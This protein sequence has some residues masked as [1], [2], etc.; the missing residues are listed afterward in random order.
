MF[1][2]CRRARS[3]LLMAFV[4]LTLILGQGAASAHEQRGV[5]GQNIVVGW[6]VEPAFTGS[7][8]AVSVRVTDA[9]SGQPVQGLQLKVEV[10]FG[11]RDSTQKT[12]PL[13]LQPAFNEPG[14]YSAPILPSRPGT[15]TFHITGQLD[16]EPFDQYFTSG[17]DTFD[18]IHNAREFPVEDPSPG[19]LA[20]RLSR[21]D[22]RIET[23][24]QEA[25]MA[26]SLA[27]GGIALG[28]IG[29]LVAL[30]ALWAARKAGRSSA[31]ASPA[32]VSATSPKE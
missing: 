31:A 11:G 6:E 30:A 16:G 8:N 9:G 17:E 21:I 28:V 23:A 1:K 4:S 19:E 20:E 10:L 3:Y 25:A 5:A 27:F 14:V 12:P 2:V 32:T 15:Y 26:R 18:S 7:P 29:L 13:D 24:S 22:S